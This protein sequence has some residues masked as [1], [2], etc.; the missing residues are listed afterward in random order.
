MDKFVRFRG[1]CGFPHYDNPPVSTAGRPQGPATQTSQF[2][3]EHIPVQ[4]EHRRNCVVCYKEG[5]GEVRYK[6]IEVHRS[7]RESICMLLSR[8]T[9]LQSFIVQSITFPILEL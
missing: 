5:R 1:I 6:P 4:G 9:A 2:V 3:T 7:V 8:G